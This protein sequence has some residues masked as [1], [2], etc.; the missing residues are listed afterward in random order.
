MKPT[1]LNIPIL[2]R[3][4][5]LNDGVRLRVLAL[6]EAEELSV[7]EVASVLQLPQSTV[8]RHLK[9]LA[10]SGWLLKRSVRT[11]VLYRLVMDD[12][13]PENRLLWAAVRTHLSDLPEHTSDQRRL[14][15]V[16]A[17]RSADSLSFFGRIAG[18]WDQHRS[19]MFGERLMSLMSPEWVVADLGCG[20]GNASEMLAPCVERVIAVDQ[21]EP[22][23]AAASRRLQAHGVHDRVDLKLGELSDLP[24]P[25][26]SV[27]AAVCLLVLHYVEEPAAAIAEASRVLRADRGGGVAL[28]VE[29][30]EH[31]RA[32]YRQRMGHKHLGFDPDVFGGMMRD[33]G[34][35]DV[36]TRVLPTEPKATGPGLFV[37]TG[38]VTER[39]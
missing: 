36:R 27:D 9:I 6:L 18:E 1:S 37:A 34:F 22:M 38:R 3:L 25:D 8:S 21:S 28:I 15:D 5:G 16:V 11:A 39:K 13:P 2:G 23:L 19:E 29:M 26:G 24:I 20:T 4:S 12:L 7:G 33:A 14:K 32:E 17:S 10:D 35:R 30:L 31:Q